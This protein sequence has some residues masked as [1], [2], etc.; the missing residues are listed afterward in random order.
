MDQDVAIC[1]CP[2][3][4]RVPLILPDL[5]ERS[6]AVLFDPVAAAAS[7]RLRTVMA[8]RRSRCMRV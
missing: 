8:R 7:E 6:T 1:H 5:M 2:S 3:G 4:S